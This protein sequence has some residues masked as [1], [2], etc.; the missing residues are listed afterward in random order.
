[1]RIVLASE[2]GQLRLK[3][4]AADI[5]DLRGLIITYF[6]DALDLTLGFNSFD[7]D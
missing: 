3:A 2:Q 6:A 1:M 7:G 4:L 5:A